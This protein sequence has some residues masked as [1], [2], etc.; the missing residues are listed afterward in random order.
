MVFHDHSPLRHL[1][2]E[3]VYESGFEDMRRRV[4]DVSKLQATIGFAP[5]IPLERALESIIHYFRAHPAGV[6]SSSPNRPRQPAG[7]G[8]WV[9]DSTPPVAVS[10]SE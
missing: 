6:V 8:V 5:S 3:Q 4:P 1:P 2:Y 10:E 9:L 7:T